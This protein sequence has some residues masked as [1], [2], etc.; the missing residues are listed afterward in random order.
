MF[1]WSQFPNAPH[2]GQ[3]NEFAFPFVTMDP[4]WDD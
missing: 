2:Y 1:S 3:P 4:K